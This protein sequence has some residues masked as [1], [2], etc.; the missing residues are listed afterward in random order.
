VHDVKVPSGRGNALE[1]RRSHTDCDDVNPA[2]ASRMR[3]S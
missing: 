2:S 3:I 1:H